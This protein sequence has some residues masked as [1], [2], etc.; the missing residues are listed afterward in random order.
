VGNDGEAVI[1][2]ND[3]PA[4]FTATAQLVS[5]GLAAAAHGTA[6]LTFDAAA[7]SVSFTI[8]LAN[9]PGDADLAHIHS[10]VKDFLVGLIPV[11]PRDGS[12]SGTVAISRKAIID[13]RQNTTNYWVEI[14]LSGSLPSVSGTLVLAH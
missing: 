8:T 2:A 13:I 6:S 10:K 11:P 7:S 14:H 12:V 1:A 4:V 3:L 9:A 5:S